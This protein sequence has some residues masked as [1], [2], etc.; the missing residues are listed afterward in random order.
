MEN[1]HPRVLIVD[2]FETSINKIDIATESV[3]EIIQK[4]N[5]G[6][7][8]KLI[9]IKKLND[10]RDM[11]IKYLTEAKLSNLN[12][13]STIMVD[14]FEKKWSHVFYDQR[15]SFLE[16]LDQLKQEQILTDC[17]LFGRKDVANGLDLWITPWFY[18]D[19]N[20]ESIKYN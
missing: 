7:S 19:Q 9:E 4:S 13:F 5:L 8:S 3:V 16:K 17:I 14:L 12:N 11:Q 6:E 15:L 1:F 10:L 18:N 20:L 2:H